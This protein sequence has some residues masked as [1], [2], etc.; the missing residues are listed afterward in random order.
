MPHHYQLGIKR[1]DKNPLDELLAMQK[2]KDSQEESTRRANLSALKN[3]PFN[4][5]YEKEGK[6]YRT[7]LTENG[8]VEDELITPS[9]YAQFQEQNLYRNKLERSLGMRPTVRIEPKPQ[10]EEKSNLSKASDFVKSIFKGDDKK[11]KATT[12]SAEPTEKKTP[13]TQKSTKPVDLSNPTMDQKNQ[14]A[15]PN[16]SGLNIG[17]INNVGGKVKTGLMDSKI[18]E[19][20]PMPD[21]NNPTE[22]AYQK[23]LSLKGKPAP[24]PVRSKEAPKELSP[25]DIANVRERRHQRVNDMIQSQIARKNAMSPTEAYESAMDRRVPRNRL[26]LPSVEGANA[27]AMSKLNAYRDEQARIKEFKDAGGGKKIVT[28]VPYT[29]SPIYSTD[30]PKVRGR[31]MDVDDSRGYRSPAIDRT[32]K[33]VGDFIAKPEPKRG[34]VSLTVGGK[35]I[36]VEKRVA[37]KKKNDKKKMTLSDKWERFISRSRGAMADTWS[38]RPRFK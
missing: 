26:S 22:I 1:L 3:F 11:P 18:G 12:V 15:N 10:P 32:V 9:Q 5:V 7:I 33:A 34:V 31:H 28:G 8:G 30:Q 13:T 27:E 16:V 2:A 20:S 6:Y 23:S 24:N 29:I 14:L 4:D 38:D 17:N 19:T 37:Q 36:P 35:K 21:M 25:Q